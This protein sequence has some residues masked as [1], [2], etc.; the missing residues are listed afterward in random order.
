[1]KIMN[2]N[3]EAIRAGYTAKKEAEEF[4]TSFGTQGG[5]DFA[6]PSGELDKRNQTRMAGPG[7]AFAMK[8]MED[9]E[10]Q[11]RVGA[12]TEQFQQS[13]PGMAFF[14]SGEQEEG[15]V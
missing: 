7:G 9:P 15:E 1:M 3:P 12:W 13:P 8:M 14:M 6:S 4:P 2:Y 5:T 10:L 11:A